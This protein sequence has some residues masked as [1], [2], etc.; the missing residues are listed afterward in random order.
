MNTDLIII[1][2]YCDNSIAEPQFIKLLGIEGLIDV[3]EEEWEEDLP[4]I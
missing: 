3:V 4:E 2:E 1:S